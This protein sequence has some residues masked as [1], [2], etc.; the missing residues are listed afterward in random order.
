MDKEI[1][2]VMAPASVGCFTDGYLLDD[3]EIYLISLFG[4]PTRVN[5]IKAAIL[6]GDKLYVQPCWSQ[7][8]KQRQWLRKHRQFTVLNR[9]LAPH[10]AH[11]LLFAPQLL[12]PEDSSNQKVFFGASMKAIYRKFFYAAQKYYSTPLLPEWTEWLWEEMEVLSLTAMGFDQAFMVRFCNE[13]FLEKR[14]FEYG[15]PIYRGE[16]N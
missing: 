14:L 6:Q 1:K 11:S 4:T 3:E 12:N 13:E 10:V 16:S 7:D 9:K 2:Q 8:W 15:S 5:A